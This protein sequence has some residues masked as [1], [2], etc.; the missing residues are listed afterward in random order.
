MMSSGICTQPLLPLRSDPSEQS[1]MISQLLFGELFEVL[2]EHGSWSKIRNLSDDYQ[3]WC[4]TK[5]LQLLPLPFFETIEKKDPIFT[6]V[7]LSACLKQGESEPRLF[8]PAGSRLYFFDEESKFFP[9]WRTRFPGEDKPEKEYWSINPDFLGYT[10]KTTVQEM[11]RTAMLFMNAPYLWGGKSILGIDCSGLTQLVYSI[12]GIKL[13][14][15]ACDQVI[16]GMSVSN[17]FE[18]EPGDLA[19]FSN[20]EGKV[21]H[22]GILLD[23]NRILHASGCVHIDPIDAEGIYNEVLGRYT[24][25]LF[26]IRRIIGL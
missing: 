5:M 19:F 6:N 4:T 1:E 9:I 10:G 26:S 22:V 11:I 15:N 7:P 2:E 17:L 14:R 8:L 21:V 25:H 24:H 16:Q 18:A 20:T 23:R 3:G 12:L 13:S